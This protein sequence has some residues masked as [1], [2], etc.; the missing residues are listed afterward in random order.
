[1]CS[2]LTAILIPYRHPHGFLIIMCS[3]LTAILMASLSLCAHTLPPSSWLPYHYVLIPYRHPHGFLIIMCSYLTAILMASL[4]LCAHTL[5][6]SSWLPYHYVLIPYR[7]P[8]GFLI[9]MCSSLTAILMASLSLC[10]HT[11]PPSSWLPYH[12]VLIPYR[13]PHGFLIIMC[14]YLTASPYIRSNWWISLIR[15]AGATATGTFDLQLCDLQGRQLSAVHIGQMVRLVALFTPGPGETGFFVWRC[16]A[17]DSFP[18]PQAVY[19]I[20]LDGYVCRW[21]STVAE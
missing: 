10:A 21:L 6:P 13:H 9:I 15:H 16:R 1:M 8:H 2:S 11:L 4:S 19:D 20:I 18:D 3:Y 17:G 14:S 12:Y 5:P 7:H